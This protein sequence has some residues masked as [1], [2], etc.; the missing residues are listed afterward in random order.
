MKSKGILLLFWFCVL[1]FAVVSCNSHSKQPSKENNSIACYHQVL[2]YPNEL[3]INL[4]T[5][6]SAISSKELKN[7]PN[8][9]IDEIGLS[10]DDLN[11]YAKFN[12]R[13]GIITYI[14]YSELINHWNYIS[15]TKDIEEIT[16]SIPLMKI[17]VV[18]CN[19][20]YN[21]NLIERQLD[22]FEQI[23]SKSN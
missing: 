10:K 7:N 21:K 20:A 17:A 14:K 23:L 4:Y 5:E 11:E 8:I 2:Q 12:H 19:D 22:Y 13:R 16:K 6:I 15:F 1:L 9:K 18:Q 3:P